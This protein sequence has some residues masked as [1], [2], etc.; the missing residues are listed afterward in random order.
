MSDLPRRDRSS[1]RFLVPAACALVLASCGLREPPPVPKTALESVIPKLASVTPTNGKFALGEQTAIG[2]RLEDPELKAIAEYLAASLRPAT[3]LPLPVTTLTAAA[4]PG[5]VRLTT[6]AGDP[7]LGDEGYTLTIDHDGVSLSAYRPAG[8]FWGVQ[9]LRQLLPAGLEG[10]ARRPGPWELET[11]RIRDVP[12]FAWRGAML[13]VARSF[14]GVAELK[15]YIDGMAYYKLNRFH[16]HL[17]DDQG[18]RIEIRSRPKLTETS[19]ATAIAGGNTGFLSQ[20]EYAEIVAYARSRYIV[21]V[22]EID[23]PGHT[24]AA[25]AAYAELSCDGKLREPYA[26]RDV[27]FSSLCIGPESTYRFVD[28]VVRELAA[29]TPGPWIHVGGDEASETRPADYPVFMQRALAIVRSHGKQP[30][31]WEEIAAVTP[32]GDTLVQ[33]WIPNGDDLAKKAVAQGA[34]LIMSPASRVYLDM[35]YNRSTTRLGQDWAGRIEV[36]DA[37]DWDPASFVEGVAEGQ[38]VGVE[39]ALWSETLRTTADVEYMAFPRLPV[40]AEI[41]WSPATGRSWLDFRD[42]LRNHGPKLSAMGVGF[43]RSPQVPWVAGL[44]AN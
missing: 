18:W 17:S 24:N 20:A 41:A 19:G 36:K 38:I 39:A 31:G 11:G 3:G 25:L 23:M 10:A 32:L 4:A 26:G 33:H 30:I 8:L 7:A 13:D 43:Y 44:D 6:S 5:G 35:Q 9:T 27:G 34:K 16:I 12:R 1:R 2:T 28:D 15:R 42:R 40:V 22:P 37:Y 14:F 21:V 29:L